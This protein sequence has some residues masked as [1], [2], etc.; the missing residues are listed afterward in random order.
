MPLALVVILVTVTIDAMGIGLI[1]PV[2]PSL[3]LD[4]RGGTLSDAA[5]WGGILSTSFAVMAG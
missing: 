3:I 5:I 4:V 1:I 2:M